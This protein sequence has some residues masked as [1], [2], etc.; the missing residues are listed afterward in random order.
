MKP[1]TTKEWFH[2]DEY[3]LKRVCEDL[4]FTDLSPKPTK[5]VTKFAHTR[6]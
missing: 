6:H 3:W 2:A 1:S 5:G 4:D